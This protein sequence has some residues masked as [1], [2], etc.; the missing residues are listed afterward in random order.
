[1]VTWYKTTFALFFRKRWLLNLSIILSILFLIVKSLN[2]ILLS[3]LL[4]VNLTLNL[5]K[6]LFWVI[7]AENGINR[8][9]LYVLY[10]Y[11]FSFIIFI[12]S[13]L[14][15]WK[16]HLI[17]FVFQGFFLNV[18]LYKTVYIY[19][20]SESSPSLWE[21]SFLLLLSCHLLPY[22][23]FCMDSKVSLNY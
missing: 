3:C 6:S 15:L 7:Y 5:S 20:R 1:M 18:C 11:Q 21:F 17:T 13:Y 12:I 19:V 2:G 22:L 4:S 14:I 23:D 9:T 16:S 8:H 10:F